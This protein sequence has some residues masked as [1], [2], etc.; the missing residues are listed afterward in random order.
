MIWGIRTAIKKLGEPKKISLK[1]AL[2][3]H[4]IILLKYRFVNIEN[5]EHFHLRKNVTARRLTL[6][7]NEFY[8][9]T[10]RDDFLKIMGEI[11]EGR[12]SGTVDINARHVDYN[13]VLLTIKPRIIGEP[14]EWP[15][16]KRAFNFASEVSKTSKD[17]LIYRIQKMADI[18]GNIQAKIAALFLDIPAEDLPA[19]FQK[20]RD[21]KLFDL[22][23]SVFKIIRRAQY[24]RDHF[25]FDQAELENDKKYIYRKMCELIRGSRTPQV[26]LLFFLQKLSEARDAKDSSANIFDEIRFLY[27][28]LAER[29]GLIFLADDFR[30]QWLRLGKPTKHAEIVGKVY[31]LIKMSYKGAKIFLDTYTREL[32]AILQKKL[33]SIYQEIT[34]KFRV[35]SF[36][37]Q[38]RCWML[39]WRF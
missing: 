13:Q 37:I 18:E 25:E 20:V 5:L 15:V 6:A 1:M 38:T 35:K 33:K 8:R 19:L 34:G 7:A 27:A 14:S 26:L 17:E 4:G 11:V 24:L 23:D 29:L 21:E 3:K 16:L 39:F 30:D 31:E 10:G 2:N 22:S 36:V 9:I 28:P 12:S 32:F